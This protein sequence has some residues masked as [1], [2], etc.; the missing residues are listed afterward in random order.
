MPHHCL[1]GQVT[2]GKE[3]SCLIIAGSQEEA[4]QTWRTIVHYLCVYVGVCPSVNKHLEITL[5]IIG[6]SYIQLEL[7]I[8]NLHVVPLIS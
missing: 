8:T 2:G 3:G 6:L 4:A 5:K 1:L 7:V